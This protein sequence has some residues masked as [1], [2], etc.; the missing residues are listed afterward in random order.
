M[1]VITKTETIPALGYHSRFWCCELTEIKRDFIAERDW[2]GRQEPQHHEPK[3]LGSPE[4][5]P[6]MVLLWATTM[7]YW[8]ATG[9]IEAGK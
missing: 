4:F 6:L 2:L 5:P 7:G 3:P 8:W 9:C 1:G